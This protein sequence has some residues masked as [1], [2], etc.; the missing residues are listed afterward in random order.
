VSASV[1]R[2]HDSV[3][4]V[5]PQGNV[6]LFEHPRFPKRAAADEPGA[7]LAPM[8]GAV[9]AV[10][11]EV[12]QAVSAGDQLVIVEAMKMEHRIQSPIDG[13]VAAVRVTVGQQVDA[14]DV[15]VVVEVEDPPGTAAEADGASD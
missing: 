2:F 15:L 4:V 10:S 11:V 1:H 14:G 12:G 13:V 7:T 9:V 6:T 3:Q 5:L 8:P